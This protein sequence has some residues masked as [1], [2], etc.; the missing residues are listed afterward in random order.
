[1]LRV[2]T[3]WLYSRVRDHALLPQV[4]KTY[5]TDRPANSAALSPIF[6]HVRA[7]PRTAQLI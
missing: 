5:P 2:C 7:H 6:D 4:L 1:M 3:R